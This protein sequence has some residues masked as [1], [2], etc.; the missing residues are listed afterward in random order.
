[1]NMSDR[2]TLARQARYV[3]L[4]VF[5]VTVL[6]LVGWGHLFS[7]LSH[8]WH[9]CVSLWLAAAVAVGVKVMRI[10]LFR[11]TCYCLLAELL[12]LY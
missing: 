4:A 5:I 10:N 3:R 1:M 12:L 11:M 9:F 2:K 8:P 7:P 6:L